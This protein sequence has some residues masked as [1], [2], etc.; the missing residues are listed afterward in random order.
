MGHLDGLD[1]SIKIMY[2]KRILIDIW[3]RYRAKTVSYISYFG[4]LEPKR[5]FCIASHM[6][7]IDVQFEAKAAVDGDG[8]AIVLSF[9]TAATFPKVATSFPVAATTLSQY[10]GFGGRSQSHDLGPWNQLPITMPSIG[11]LAHHV[12]NVSKAF[13]L[14]NVHGF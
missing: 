3:S 6:V 10:F 1:E 11:R 7:S 12:V 8:T 5:Q 14:S 9:S 13:L 2:I 4:D